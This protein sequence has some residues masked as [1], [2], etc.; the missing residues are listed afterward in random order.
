MKNYDDNEITQGVLCACLHTLYRED[1]FYADP[2]FHKYSL[3][4]PD[5]SET[6][7]LFE[8][9]SERFL[10]IFAG[11]QLD[12]KMR[13]VPK[14]ETTVLNLKSVIDLLK[15]RNERLWQ[16]SRW[17]FDGNFR[18]LDGESNKNNK[19]AFCS[20]PRSGNTFLRKYLELLTGVATGSDNT[21]AVNVF[22]QM[23]GMKGEDTVDDTVWIVKSHSPWIMPDVPVFHAQKNIVVVRNPL[24]TNLSW[25]H[26]VAT[27]CHSHKSP[28]DYETEYPQ[29]F[30]WWVK[31][32]CK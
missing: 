21:L 18:F 29:W 19:V 27:G 4:G 12:N 25:L 28:F 32:C 13:V 14:P 15:S 30:D 11:Y 22:L 17:I 8:R 26:L 20:F 7:R 6:K 24:D 9:F 16:R 5:G 10:R 23:Q 3:T 2:V 1:T 31:D